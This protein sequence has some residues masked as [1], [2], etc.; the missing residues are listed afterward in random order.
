MCV[1]LGFGLGIMGISRVHTCIGHFVAALTMGNPFRDFW[2]CER[3]HM[4][5]GMGRPP[6]SRFM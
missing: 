1:S 4:M 3:S 6:C 2:V 5:V